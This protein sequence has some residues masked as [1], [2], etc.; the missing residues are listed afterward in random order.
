[1]RL[2]PSITVQQA[3]PA[4]HGGYFSL[5]EGA[6]DLNGERLTSGEAVYITCDGFV[7]TRAEQQSELRLADTLRMRD[8]A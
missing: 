8:R 7:R 2:D 6:V 1:M 3:L 5:I 4:G